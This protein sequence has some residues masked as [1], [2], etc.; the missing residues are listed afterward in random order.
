MRTAYLRLLQDWLH[1]LGRGSISSHGQPP[2]CD[3]E[4]LQSPKPHLLHEQ[5]EDPW[6]EFARE[7]ERLAGESG[8]EV[9]E[10]L[11]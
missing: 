11:A 7:R 8:R 6:R 5:P 1:P 10:C 9:V 3:R 2:E 4:P